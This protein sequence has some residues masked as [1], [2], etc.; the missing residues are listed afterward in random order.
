MQSSG[1]IGATAQ[2]RLASR[3]VYDEFLGVRVRTA[4]G[5]APGI[6]IEANTPRAAGAKSALE[7]L[8]VEESL[9][10]P[11]RS[12]E[13]YHFGLQALVFVRKQLSG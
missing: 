12:Q 1:L 10:S 6:G 8:A 9:R 13:S 3:N 11:D 7:E 5:A 2:V 4:W